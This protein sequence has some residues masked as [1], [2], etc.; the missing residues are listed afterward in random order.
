MNSFKTPIARRKFLQTSGIAGLASAVGLEARAAPLSA[1][2]SR[3]PAFVADKYTI[4]T[5]TPP[6]RD[7]GQGEPE[8]YY[9]AMSM[10][11]MPGGRLV[12]A[13]PRGRRD[14]L[15]GL[16][17]MIISVS[18]DAGLTW[19]NVAE[20]PYDSGEPVLYVHE[21]RLYQFLSPNRPESERRTSFPREGNGRIWATV[22]DDEGITWSKP[23]AVI[24]GLPKYTSGGQTALVVQHG[25]LYWTISERYQTL[26]VVCCQLD[27]GILNPAAWRISDLVEMPIPPEVVW[28]KYD[29]GSTMR[30]LEGNVVEVGGRLLVVARAVINRYA[31]ANLAALF[32]IIDDP[33]TGR[34]RLEFLQLYPVPGAQCKFYIERDP[35]AGLY[36][37]AS[38]LPTNSHDLI[39]IGRKPGAGRALQ[40]REKWGVREDRRLL[41]LWYSLDAL[42]WIPAGW[43]AKADGWDQ[44][45]MYPVILIDG[46]DIL[47]I[48]RTARDSGN[49]HDVDLATFHR[50]REFRNLAVNLLPTF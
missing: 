30:C 26:A 15:K 13:T 38:N 50:I 18:D 46:N 22:S 42:N 23:V 36:W 4:I 12:A 5:R 34:L 2:G 7:M 25:R 44:S 24:S 43:I 48:S 19:R 40:H 21:G 47:V 41:T 45:F 32:E 37:M 49:Y 20:L 33:E 16:E 10:V 14:P 1:P 29:D 27:R 3:G 11:K 31:T 35:V 6:N 9:M 17:A 8:I 28:G 39:Q